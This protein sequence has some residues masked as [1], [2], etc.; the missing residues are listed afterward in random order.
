[1]TYGIINVGR[2][3]RRI[4]IEEKDL[5]TE[6]GILDLELFIK[7]SP[8]SVRA[9]WTDLP[10]DYTAQDPR[11]Q[12]F[13]IVTLTQTPNGREL[14]TYWRMP[15]GS[16]REMRELLALK[17]DGNWT[18]EIPEHPAGFHVFDEFQIEPVE[19]GTK[20][21]IRSTLTPRTTSAARSIA[22]QKDRMAQAWKI[23]GEICERDAT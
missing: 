17:P 13:R 6:E 18:F 19:S 16:T 8:A 21:H 2:G 15:D 3:L 10:D 23:A 7:R 22:T 11:E 12:P 14:R 5:A 9:W 4:Y 1:M 20:L